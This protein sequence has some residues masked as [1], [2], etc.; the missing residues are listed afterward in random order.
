MTPV[1]GPDAN[2]E[3]G[4]ALA[5]L[6]ARLVRVPSVNPD[7]GEGAVLAFIEEWLERETTAELTRVE[8]EPG[9][10]SLAAVIRGEKPGPRLILNGHMDTV[11][12]GARDGWLHDP[13]GG[14]IADGRVYGRG[15]CDMKGGLAVALWTARHVSRVRERF[16]GELVLHLAAGE[17]RGEP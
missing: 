3:V 16:G 5:Q 6:T 11:G 4:Q 9:R 17:E 2:T 14:T 7:D 10:H 1:V 8:L 15:A 13:F 12:I